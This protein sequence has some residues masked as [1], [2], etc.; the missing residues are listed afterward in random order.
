MNLLRTFAFTSLVVLLFAVRPAHAQLAVYGTV[1]TSNYGYDLYDNVD[2]YYNGDKG[3][4]GGGAVTSRVEVGEN[5]GVAQRPCRGD[6]VAQPAVEQRD[7]LVDQSLSEHRLG[8][9][10]QSLV[11]KLCV[12]I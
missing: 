3:S 10:A 11:E 5:L 12:A 8:P 6:A 9:P 1:S 7:H 4:F 2:I